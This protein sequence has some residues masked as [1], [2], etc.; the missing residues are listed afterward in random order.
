MGTRLLP[1]V[2]GQDIQFTNFGQQ[3][4]EPVPRDQ[5]IAGI[6]MR[7]VGQIDVVDPGAGV[8]GTALA[9]NPLTVI[10]RIQ[11]IGGGRDNIKDVISV[12]LVPAPG[13]G[14]IVER[15][16]FRRWPSFCLDGLGRAICARPVP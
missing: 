3:R 13:A 4:R 16:T 8:A 5:M 11:L 2:P 15:A 14:T 10:P 7:L 12:R 6:D 9:E 1:F